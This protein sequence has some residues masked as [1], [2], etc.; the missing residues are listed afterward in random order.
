MLLRKAIEIVSTLNSMNLDHWLDRQRDERQVDK[1][2]Q[3]IVAIEL[4]G[5]ISLLSLTSL[6]SISQICLSLSGLQAQ[7]PHASVYGR[8]AQAIS[9]IRMQTLSPLLTFILSRP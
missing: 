4:P 5:L 8:L 9:G 7:P 6:I 3:Q 2:L 1:I